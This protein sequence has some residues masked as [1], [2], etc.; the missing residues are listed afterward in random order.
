[1]DYT[2]F[3][4]GRN[5]SPEDERDYKLATFIPRYLGDLSGTME[6]NYT[7]EL[8]DQGSKPHCTGFGAANFCNNPPVENKYSNTDGDRFYYMCKEID[9]E[10]EQE[11]GSTTRTVGKM[12]KKIGRIDHY[13]FANSVNE[14]TYWLLHNGPIMCGV[15]WTTEMFI[16]DSNNIIHPL[17]DV[18]GGHFLIA[19]ATYLN[20]FYRL[21][22]S[23]DNMWGVNGEALISIEDFAT[24]L[25]RQ[26]DA[27][28][29]V[30]LPVGT[31]PS[32]ENKGCSA[33]LSQIMSLL[34]KNKV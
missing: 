34:G 6:W 27:M 19:N 1:M 15:P 26:G 30:E 2:R 33:F 23:W 22:N 12:L 31:M 21:H 10:P 16:P 17:G 20:K 5:P 25:K 18:V 24:L 3:G 9:G 13:A 29:A 11:N 14:I 28:T 4:L 32:P 7:G 8:L